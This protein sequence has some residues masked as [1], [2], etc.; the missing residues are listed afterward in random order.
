MKFVMYLHSSTGIVER[1]N[2]TGEISKLIDKYS[3]TT[4][5]DLAPQSYLH[6]LF[7]DFRGMEELTDW[8]KNNHILYFYR[9]LKPDDDTVAALKEIADS[10]GMS[11]DDFFGVPA[12]DDEWIKANIES[13]KQPIIIK[14]NSVSI[15][16]PK[17]TKEIEFAHIGFDKKELGDLLKIT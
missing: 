17:S 4:W 8:L 11:M 15:L 5:N 9:L 1:G 2:N 14:R 12:G 3:W 7:S 13:I 10:Q 16:S 6:I